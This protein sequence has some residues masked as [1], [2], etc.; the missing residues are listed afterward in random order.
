MA[1]SP[2]YV[3][4]LLMEL[5]R[6]LEGFHRRIN[7]VEELRHYEDT[8]ALA[9]GEKTSGLEVRIG[10]TAELI[11][12]VK[13]SLTANEAHVVAKALRR[14]DTADENSSKR[15][16]F[17]TTFLHWVNRP[18][19]VLNELADGQ[20]V[21]LGILK[22][23]YTPW[24]KAPR[25]RNK[26]EADTEYNDRQR[27][28]KRQ[29]GPP[30]QVI[31]VHPLTF[32]FRLGP[33]NRVVEC[34]EH[35]WKSKRE[36]YGTYGIGD[37]AQLRAREA[38]LN[39]SEGE[40][41]PEET[42]GAIAATAGQPD[43]EIRP[44]P[45]GISS[46]TMALVTEY[47]SDT[48]YQCYVNGRLIYSEEGDPG[49]RYF[50]AVGR[51]TSSKDPDKF[52]LSVAEAFRHNE[53][54]INRTITRMAEAAEILV[55]KRL[56]LELPEG[57]TPEMEIGEDN[58]PQAKQY[59]FTSEKATALPPGAKV[60]D[61]FVGAENVYQAMPFVE[62]LLRLMGQ[63]G[64]AP[65]FKGVPPGAAGSGYRD[66]S[67]Y[68]MAKSQFQYL[69]DSNAGC[70]AD[71][72]NWLERQLVRRVKQEIW[73]EDL[74]LK[75]SDVRDWPVAITVDIDPLLPQNIIAE[76][77]FYDR[78][79]A[80][81]H[82]TRRTMLEK[83]LRFEQ[84]EDEMWGTM[85]EDIQE[86]LKP[87]LYQD[88]LGIVMGRIGGKQGL[89][90]PDGQPIGGGAGGMPRGD[91]RRGGIVGGNGAAD[92]TIQDL[93]HSIGGGTRAGQPRQPPEMAGMTPPG[94]V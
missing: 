22:A 69:L 65:I 71:L 85:L 6:E 17:W 64:V 40:Q 30:F 93:L 36:V 33:G 73:V 68:A 3:S 41:V 25:K 84:P 37:D 53:P 83:G 92:Q 87:M 57:T 77:Q 66:N 74:S 75:P 4:R 8:M 11:E 38:V 51:T 1:A 7:E 82:I 2:Q 52:G 72:I 67:L 90:G 13:A 15:E 55:R 79:H 19:P 42:Q 24:P 50:L 49:V 56:T 12:N 5:K 35:S 54:T 18:V 26:G 70:L 86:Q 20:T 47:L 78:M 62:L 10:A 89:V 59:K 32:Y 9:P 80:R 76:G 29:W 39:L 14:G 34:I 91:A 46:D 60:Q 23:V 45:S 58:Q 16:R 27:A 94:Q 21:G 43:Q 28:L 31:T 63:H 44:F 88:V 48:E 81:R 61:P